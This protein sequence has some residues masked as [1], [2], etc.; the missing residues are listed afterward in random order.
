MASPMATIAASGTPRRSTV[1]PTATVV[2]IRSTRRWRRC[3]SC[4]AR[5]ASPRSPPRRS[6]R[7]FRCCSRTRRF[8]WR[9]AGTRRRTRSS[10]ALSLR[11]AEAVKAYLV[12]RGIQEGRLR[13]LGYRDEQPVSADR[14]SA[15]RAKN[16]RVELRLLPLEAAK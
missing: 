10:R 11:R 16:R 4:G 13:V 8:A 14:S 5:W 6:T 15:G 2:L 9:S 1:T 3:R 7:P 12:H